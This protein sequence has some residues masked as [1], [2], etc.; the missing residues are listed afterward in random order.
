MENKVIKT[1]YSEDYCPMKERELAKAKKEF[2][3][4]LREFIKNLTGAFGRKKRIEA[5]SK[6]RLQ[7]YLDVSWDYQLDNL[8][9]I[10][11][12]RSNTDKEGIVRI[13]VSIDR[14]E[15]T[16]EITSYDIGD[17]EKGWGF[18]KEEAYDSYLASQTDTTLTKETI[19]KNTLEEIQKRVPLILNLLREK[20]RS[21]HISAKVRYQVFM[22][23]DGKC[24]FCGSNINI[25]FDHVIPFSKGGAHTVDNIRVLCQDCNRSRSDNIEKF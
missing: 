21:R 23:D 1:F 5:Y 9:F 6:I 16:G 17:T 24:V 15:E 8:T 13:T 14:D 4:D 7:K 11:I 18:I 20:P 12:I 19:L 10:Y 22:R 25:E 3:K 2:Q